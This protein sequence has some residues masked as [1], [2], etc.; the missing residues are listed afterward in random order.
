MC[1]IAGDFRHAPDTP[2]EQLLRAMGAAMQYRGPD[3]EGFFRGPHIGL[4]HRRLSIRDLS[5]AGHCPM[6]S[7]DGTIQVT[8]NGEIYNWRELRAELEA[9]GHS[10]ASQ[11]DTEV[12]V[13][14]YLA[15]QED[16][17]PRLRG[18]FAIAIWDSTRQQLLLAR[19]RLGEKPLFYQAGPA[20]VRFGSSI[21]ALAAVQYESLIDPDAVA[22]YLSHSFVPATHTIWQGV[23][24]L[25]PANLLLVSPGS[26]LRVEPY[27]ELPRRGPNRM[28]VE[29]CLRSTE[30]SL[31]DSVERCLD[32][33]VPV[34]VFLSGGVDSSIVSAMAAHFQ[35]G[36]PAFSL[37]FGERDFS[38]L[39]Y[40]RRVA[41]H[42][43]VPHHIVEIG[44]SDLL[45]CLPH[46]V[47]QYGQPFGDAS[48]VPSYLVSRLARQHVKVC[49][50][51]DGGDES[52]GGYWRVQAGVYSHRYGQLV[53]G[54]LRR[55]LVPGLAR[56]LG[57][58][59]R[60]LTAMNELSIAEPG[61]G[62]TN[63]ASWHD[64][65]GELAGPRLQ[66]GLQHDR[67][68]CR[69]GEQCNREE[70][71]VVQRMLAGDFQVQ[72][73]DD[74]L[75]K[76]DIAS[77]AASLEVRAPFLDQKVVEQAWVLPDRT[78]LHWGERKWILK[79]IAARWVPRDVVYRPKMGFA[80]PLVHWWRGELGS[81]LELLMRDSVAAADGWIQ[82]EPVRQLLQAHRRGED[83]HTRLW[84]ILWL[85]L[86][87]RL[88]VHRLDPADLPRAA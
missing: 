35:P 6:A 5:P 71:S 8:F 36:L 88:V 48:A 25:P 29:E 22:C 72:L 86:W 63:A 58:L 83:H 80:L 56:Q 77:M 45:G 57:G 74:Y 64:R 11:S 16:L 54:I 70:A 18:M 17:I 27:W 37:G 7:A 84:L 28:G 65:L 43:K 21:E 1:G 39:P 49:L 78:K 44:I 61:V 50:S 62:Y 60:R 2:D 55:H 14:G 53:P 69:N 40:A 42:L 4:V 75:T 66:P 38:E 31:L 82:G 30:S 26:G 34:G 47:V 67:A 81:W 33:D 41:A 15:W 52:F 19:D 59:G 32:A 10:F 85:E 46:L 12:I 76:V 24:V 51:G 13:Q 73:P 68:L 79:R 87:F 23:S 20:G 3:D 9:V